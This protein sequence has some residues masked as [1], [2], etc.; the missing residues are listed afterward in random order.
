MSLKA[1][2]NEINFSHESTLCEHETLTMF[3]GLYFIVQVTSSKET[4]IDMETSL[5]QSLHNF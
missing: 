3:S 2:V 4:T 1:D 5:L